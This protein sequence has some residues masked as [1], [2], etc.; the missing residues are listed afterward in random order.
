[1]LTLFL[2]IGI[3]L[4]ASLPAQAGPTVMLWDTSSPLTAPVDAADRAEWKHVP[5]DLLALEADPLKAR[6]DPAYYGREYV[7]EGDAV[8]ENDKLTA[9][10]QKAAGRFLV[11][12]K[13]AGS[14]GD[15]L[16]E[17][18]PF[19]GS[20]QP[21]SIQNIEILQNAGDEVVLDVAFSNSGSE[22][23]S[24]VFTFDKTEI[25]EMKPA[26]DRK[27]ISLLASI[28]YGI[29]PCF[30][31]DDLI[32][33]AGDDPSANV[34][35]VPSEN[36]FVGL[37]HGGDRMLVMTWPSGNQQLN[38]RVE[39]S[40]DRTP[41][42]RRISTVDFENDGKSVYLAALQAPGIWHR[43]ELKA[44]FLEKEVPANWKRPFPAKWKTQ[45][46]E[47]GVKTT[48]AF[49]DSPGTV[50]RGVPGMY[51][52]PVWFD[53]GDA[54][55]HLTKK[56][57][58]KGESIV[59]FLEGQNTPVTVS[60]P[61]DI[62]KATLGRQLSGALL[63]APGRKLRTH[64]RRG[65]SGIRR[66]CT[67]GGTEIVQAIFEVGEELERI[68]EIGE[69]MNDTVY[70]VQEHLVRIDEYREFAESMIAFLR[71]ER[72]SH[73]GAGLESYLEGLEQIAQQIP[74]EYSVQKENM[75]SLKDANALADKT[76]AL[77][78][79]KSPDNLKTYMEL[80]QAWRAMGGAQDYV[81]AQCHTVTRKLAQEAGYGCAD[82]PEA[83]EVAKEIRERCRKIL[84][85]PDGYEIWP[86][87]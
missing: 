44:T 3:S 42:R 37:M 22:D 27:R 13:P 87:Y 85:N 39:G 21:G 76:V 31:G 28:D 48:F 84:R 77:A 15:P 20:T 11:Y 5:S 62:I 66:A 56:V 43:E 69:A 54:F 32:Y 80:F 67:C 17:F 24:A 53:G 61:V 58:P 26:Q 2:A 46:S 71:A 35:S 6:S 60:T 52:Y 25:V 63:D 55:Y 81:L 4:W 36:V 29:A 83:V 73:A 10:F 49:R 18:V 38:L 75:K 70:F 30:I 1:M 33:G 9:V 23:V 40:G 41:G 34:L 19:Q 65:D 50:W 12:P 14:N 16:V 45:L 72:K 8:V 78:R 57:L 51:R 47:A 64:H 79:K 74:Q 82:L 86:N 7:F 68:K 59:Y